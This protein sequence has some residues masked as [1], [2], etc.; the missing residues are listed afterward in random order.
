MKFVLVNNMTPR[1]PSV[2]ATCSRRSNEVTYT[3]FPH[4]DTIVEFSAT[5]D[6]EW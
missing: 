5:P 2:C 3:I 4:R 1:E 6:G